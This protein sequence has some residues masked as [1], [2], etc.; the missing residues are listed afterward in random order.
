MVKFISSA[1]L[2]TMVLMVSGCKDDEPNR[3]VEHYLN[4]AEE[5]T[6]QLAKCEVLDNAVSEANCVNA[7]KASEIHAA[8]TNRENSSNAINSL[9]GSKN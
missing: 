8:E 9:F 2:I 6:A 7:Q 1:A 3:T 5:R 4:N